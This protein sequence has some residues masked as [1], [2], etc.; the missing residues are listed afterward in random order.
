MGTIELSLISGLRKVTKSLD[1]LP[2]SSNEYFIVWL[3]RMMNA[4]NDIEDGLGTPSSVENKR[5]NRFK[6]AS[7][8]FGKVIENEDTILPSNPIYDKHF[9]HILMNIPHLTW[10]NFFL[11]MCNLGLIPEIFEILLEMVDDVQQLI[12]TKMFAWIESNIKIIATDKNNHITSLDI[13]IVATSIY[14][15]VQLL[16]RSH[17]DT[18]YLFQRLE[19]ILSSLHNTDFKSSYQP[20][21]LNNA[22]GIN[23]LKRLQEISGNFEQMNNPQH[24]E[25]PDAVH[26]HQVCQSL[27]DTLIQ[28]V[29]NEP[30]NKTLSSLKSVFDNGLHLGKPNGD[31]CKPEYSPVCTNYTRVCAEL[32]NS[33]V[34]L[35][36][37]DGDTIGAFIRPLHSL[38]SFMKDILAIKS[39]SIKP[40]EFSKHND[41]YSKKLHIIK[42]CLKD[43]KTT[44]EYLI[45]EMTENP[46]LHNMWKDYI[47]AFLSN[48]GCLANTNILKS[49]L[50]ALSKC[51]NQSNPSSKNITEYIS[52]SLVFQHM[53]WSGYGLLN[54][55]RKQ[56]TVELILSD[57]QFIHL[58]SEYPLAEYEKDSSKITSFHK[59]REKLT[60]TFFDS[61]VNKN[62][63]SG[64]ALEKACEICILW[65]E[66][67]VKKL[68]DHSLKNQQQIALIINLF[69]QLNCLLGVTMKE[70]SSSVLW[71]CYSTSMKYYWNSGDFTF[72]ENGLNFFNKLFNSNILK[73]DMLFILVKEAFDYVAEGLVAENANKFPSKL[74]LKMLSCLIDNHAFFKVCNYM[75]IISLCVCLG[76]EIDMSRHFWNSNV[77]FDQEKHELLIECFEYL[78][79][80]VPDVL[81]KSNSISPSIVQYV[82][83]A[84]AELTWTTKLRFLP[85]L[86]L[87]PSYKLSVPGCLSEVCSIPDIFESSDELSYGAGTGLLAWHQCFIINPGLCPVSSLDITK[88]T[89]DEVK[90]FSKGWNVT[91]AQVLP[92]CLPH[93]WNTLFEATKLL[94]SDF[95]L[96]NPISSKHILCLPN[97]DMN[98]CHDILGVLQ[99]LSNALELL[100]KDCCVFWTSQPIWLHFIKC[101][102]MTI[103]KMFNDS[104]NFEQAMTDSQLFMLSQ[105]FCIVCDAIVILFNLPNGKQHVSLS[106][107][108]FILALDLIGNFEKLAMSLKEQHNDSID[109]ILQ[110]DNNSSDSDS[111]ESD[112]SS[113]VMSPGSGHL[114]MV[115]GTSDRLQEMLLAASNVPIQNYSNTLMQKLSCIAFL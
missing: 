112:I 37:Q 63:T 104:A 67:M 109:T 22:C 14:I 52:I 90:L 62:E 12:V 10:N 41:E 29:G 7:I 79:R 15:S 83:G 94:L 23:M 85:I 56:K 13:F 30:E 34:T 82:D 32:I 11:T 36:F 111:T 93:E 24:T 105:A 88:L 49:I 69:S 60:K 45:N 61:L 75:E 21:L 73:N 55:Q 3:R 102:C 44:T 35:R 103:S 54:L 19:K 53:F 8:I 97:I 33:Y 74:S 6:I 16:G 101:F 71:N 114:Q 64:S 25:E 20:Y 77:E 38:N 5:C 1:E 9:N 70:S 113:P 28:N 17:H 108:L 80:N 42:Y 78:V 39:S 76:V 57:P 27:T 59:K 115:L 107:N 81:V 91:L 2:A 26:L 86:K 66:G 84:L 100:T 51:C 95:R 87:D 68:V 47:A 58:I 72:V 89:P 106:E 48:P 65:P 96:H 98:E 18:S 31:I 92:F 40:S 99:I 46:L 4:M 50:Q 43:Y 110:S